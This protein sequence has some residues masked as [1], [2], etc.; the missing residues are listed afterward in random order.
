[1]IV[2]QSLDMVVTAA[3]A[4]LAVMALWRATVQGSGM[5]RK[6]VTAVMDVLAE[7][8]VLVGMRI[9]GVAITIIGGGAVVLAGARAKS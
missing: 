7:K 5:A 6:A 3:M 4:A 2:K 1:V 8:A 9:L